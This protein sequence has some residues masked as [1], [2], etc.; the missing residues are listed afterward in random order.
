MFTYKIT[1]AFLGTAYC[2]WQVQPNGRSVCEAFQDAVEKTLGARGD[3]K[4]CSRT[5]AGVH[6]D[7]FVLALR[8]WFDIPPQGL[9]RG[10]NSTLPG[11]IAVRRCERAP[12]G[13]HPRYDCTG[14]TYLY[15]FYDG[16]TPD[17]F[18]CGRTLRCPRRL[19]EAAMDAAAKGF[20]GTHDFS[21][22]CASGGAVPEGGRTR[23]VREASVA[24]QGELVTFSVT[25]DGFL[26]HMVRIMAGTLLEVS[27]GKRTPGGIPE[28]IAAGRRERAGATAPACGLY[29]HEVSY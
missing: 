20:L 1:L 2:G 28:I 6:A 24:R 17:P 4:G 16:E 21:A 18:L 26:Y 11:D 9:M 19:D 13:F 8:C 14:K 25:G 29:L 12:E 15:K 10:L 7:G 3:V 27:A 23:T 22:F 5:D